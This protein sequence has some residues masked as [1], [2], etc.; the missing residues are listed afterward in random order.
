VAGGPAAA[1]SARPTL[2]RKP[3]RPR[4]NCGSDPHITAGH[5]SVHGTLAASLLA[6]GAIPAP[7]TLKQ[8]PALRACRRRQ[9]RK[10]LRVAIR[11]PWPILPTAQ[12]VHLP[13]Q[14][15]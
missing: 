15:G 3:L 8:P 12:M 14:Q 6:T 2:S 13:A 1:T 11:L 4:G 9:T 7:A 10:G 5:E